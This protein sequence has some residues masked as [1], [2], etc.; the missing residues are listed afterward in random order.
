MKSQTSPIASDFAVAF[1]SCGLY[2]ESIP[3]HTNGRPPSATLDGVVPD[4]VTL[5]SNHQLTLSPFFSGGV[6]KS[7][8]DTGKPVK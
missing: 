8:N 3:G 5:H 2:K 1:H 6:V 4:V 7:A